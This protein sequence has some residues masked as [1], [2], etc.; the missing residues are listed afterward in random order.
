MGQTIQVFNEK[1]HRLLVLVILLVGLFEAAWGLLQLFGIVSSGHFRYAFSGSFYNPGPYA[2]FLAV[3]M[4]LALNVS[5]HAGNKLQKTLGMSMV[6]ACAILIPASL[7]R[8]AL[9]A[10]AIGGVCATWDNISA[11]YHRTPKRLVIIL[12]IITMIAAGAICV[13][14]DSAKGRFL[15]WKIAMTAVADVPV[16]GVG[17]EHVAGCYGNAQE[18]YFAS[19]EGTDD[20]R[21]VAD[22]PMFVFNEYLQI[23]IAFG[24]IAAFCVVGVMLGGINVALNNKSRGIA[25]CAISAAVVMFASYPFQ[26]A[27]FVITITMIMLGAW[28]SSAYPIVRICGSIVTLSLCALFLTYNS[29]VDVGSRFAEGLLL[30]RSYN[31][32]ESNECLLELVGYSGDPMILNVIGKNYC[33]LGMP[34]SAEHY[35]TRS[36]HRCPNRIYPHYLLMQLYNDSAYHDHDALMRELSIVIETKEKIPSPAIDEMRTEARNILESLYGN[37]PHSVLNE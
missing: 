26:F 15:M 24:P 29:T 13:K 21:L 28:W 18:Q 19:G 17:W 30:H 7:S 1:A 32:K 36:T 14:K 20:E 6:A 12:V 25:G 9:I 16:N 8:T 33:S 3:V 27:I 10:G 37:R 23:A 4:P 11:I 5:I 34:D 31:Y 2:C 22:A 35:F